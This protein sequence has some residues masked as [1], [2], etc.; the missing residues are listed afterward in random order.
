MANQLEAPPRTAG[1]GAPP[2]GWRGHACVS[3]FSISLFH[4]T[5]LEGAEEGVKKEGEK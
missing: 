1:T 4:E 2:P 5:L 3:A